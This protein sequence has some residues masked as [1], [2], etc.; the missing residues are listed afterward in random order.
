MALR[1][2]VNWVTGRGY[3]VTDDGA[4][5]IVTADAFIQAFQEALEPAPEPREGCGRGA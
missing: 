1:G 2:A 4:K 5:R 3:V